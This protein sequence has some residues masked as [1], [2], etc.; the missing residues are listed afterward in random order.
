MIMARNAGPQRQL[1]RIGPISR[2][3]ATLCSSEPFRREDALD[4]FIGRFL[5]HLRRRVN[6]DGRLYGHERRFLVAVVITRIDCRDAEIGQF[7]S[8]CL[9]TFLRHRKQSYRAGRVCLLNVSVRMKPPLDEADDAAVLVGI[10]RIGAVGA[11]EVNPEIENPG[12][13]FRLLFGCG[14]AAAGI[15]VVASDF[16]EAGD[17]GICGHGPVKRQR[18]EIIQRA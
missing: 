11:V 18:R 4:D 9:S 15:E 13:L 7:S 14:S 17:V 6:A 10:E 8:N 3:I 1:L 2:W 5:R 16:L 12:D